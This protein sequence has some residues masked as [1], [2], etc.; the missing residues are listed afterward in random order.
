MIVKGRFLIIVRVSHI[1][2]FNTRIYAE[3]ESNASLL[4][5]AEAPQY[6]WTKSKLRRSR[7]QCKFTCDCRGAP[8]YV[9][10]VQIAQKPRAMQVYLQLPR[11]PSICG[12]S[13]NCAEAEKSSRHGVHKKSLN[14]AIQTFLC[15][16]QDSNLHALNG[17]YPLKVACL[18]ISPSGL[19]GA[20]NIQCFSE[21]ET[22][23]RNFLKFTSKFSKNVGP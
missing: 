20:A 11:R 16:E 13:P 15:P 23:F 4:A 22:F 9:D 7:E 6:M 21:K 10:E 12:R 14:H 1:P 18:P 19:I 2:N 17:H 8:V 3:A 5:I